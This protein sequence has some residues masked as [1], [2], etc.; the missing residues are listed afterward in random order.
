MS[1]KNN[2]VNLQPKK[3]STAVN[4]AVNSGF[5]VNT[6]GDDELLLS[7]GYS[8]D[9]LN[10]LREE[11]ATS[12]VT[13][14]TEVGQLAQNESILANLGEELGKFTATVQVFFRDIDDFS[15]KVKALRE[16]HEHRSGPV[17]DMDSFSQYNQITFEYHSLCNELT[18]LVTPTISQLVLIASEA[19]D[20]TVQLETEAPVNKEETNE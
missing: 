11:L 9:D 5:Q 1:E 6:E 7:N 3:I 12:V 10:K 8:W 15:N 19:V 20:N 17:T 18:V 13:F 16:K 2:V 4:K 14:V